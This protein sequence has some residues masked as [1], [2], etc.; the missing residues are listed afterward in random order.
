MI[1]SN[2]ENFKQKLSKIKV[3]LTD[4]DGV[5]T[6]GTV[7]YTQEGQLL[8]QFNVKDGLAVH[9]LHEAGLKCGIVTSDI[10]SI[11]KI[12][13]TRIRFDFVFTEAIN[14]SLILDEIISK[15]GLK[16]EEFCF[17]GDDVNDIPILNRVGLSVAPA[18][19]HSK[20]LAIVDYVSQK[21][22][23]SGVFREIAD[24]LIESGYNHD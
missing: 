12:R 15:T 19:A 22:G 7:F 21:P 10:S 14:K 5:L 1:N 16:E 6:N 11:G 24:L 23:G 20:I 17:I 8:K 2:S 13:G 18:D 3:L 9:L 4:M